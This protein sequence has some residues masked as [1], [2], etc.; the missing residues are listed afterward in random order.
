MYFIGVGKMNKMFSNESEYTLD[1]LKEYLNFVGSIIVV[2]DS[3]GNVIFVN[4]RAC[5]VL[6]GQKDEIIGKNWIENFIPPNLHESIEDI[7]A[8]K[9]YEAELIKKNRTLEDAEAI[10]HVGHFV[11]D[12][13]TGARYW[14]DE[15][16]RLFGY[17]PESNIDKSEI[18][19]AGMTI[20]DYRVFYDGFMVVSKSKDKLYE[21]NIKIKD[22]QNNTKFLKIIYNFIYK[23]DTY[24]ESFGIIQDMTAVKKTL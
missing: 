19:K 6:E 5:E 24:V 14:S 18:L 4:N 11:S 2:L 12:V 3:V 15:L 10:A 22:L 13:I 9:I 23:N 20:D 8:V 1:I 17:E 21:A 7:T 16:F